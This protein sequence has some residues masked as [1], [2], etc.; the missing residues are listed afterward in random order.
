MTRSK[1]RLDSKNVKEILNHENT[2]LQLHL[3]VK[4]SDD[5]GKDFYY[6][7][8]VKPFDAN[9]T[10]I[11]NDEGKDLSIVNIKFHIEHEVKDELYSYFVND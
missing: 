1:V 9:Q 10:T 11:K 2:G 7:G 8:R 5:E 4:K 6:I 3:F